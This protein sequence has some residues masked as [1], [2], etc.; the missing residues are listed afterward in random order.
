MA[1]KTF[2]IDA[3]IHRRFSDFCKEYGISMSRQIEMFMLHQLEENPARKREHA[4]KL[5]R[6]SRGSA[7]KEASF[8]V[9]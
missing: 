3:G 7:R 1:I 5:E 4:E 6:M 2:N 9:I 8:D